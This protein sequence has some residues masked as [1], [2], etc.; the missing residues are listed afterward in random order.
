MFNCFFKFVTHLCDR[1]SFLRSGLLTQKLHPYYVRLRS[2]LGNIKLAPDTEAIEFYAQNITRVD[3]VAKMLADKQSRREYLGMIKFRQSQCMRDYPFYTP[4]EPEY[5]IHEA[6]FGEDEVFVD[7]GAYDGD[8]INGFAKQCPHYK[9][10]V[11]FEPDMYNFTKLKSK[12]G[13]NPCITLINAGVYDYDG[14]IHFCEQGDSCSK[15]GD[16]SGNGVTISVKAIDTLNIPKITFM[17][18]DIEGA[19][20][21]AIKGAEK[22]IVRDKPKLA[23]CIYH[24]NEDML[25]IPEYIHAL[26][27]EYRLYVRHHSYFPSSGETVLYALMP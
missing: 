2:I 16:A 13:T 1:Y 3:S 27:P 12:H 22:T 10:I 17:K 25:R 24:S 15:I 18:M 9:H 20:L 6:T 7:C 26:V 5:F 21:N 14:E 11:A 8:T 23:I 19:E 4:K